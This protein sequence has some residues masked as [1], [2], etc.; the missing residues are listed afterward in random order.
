LEVNLRKGGTTH[1]YTVLRNLVPGRYDSEHGRWLAID[2]RFGLTAIGRS[3]EQ[4]AELYQATKSAV[5]GH[6]NP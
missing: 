3:Q 4:A 5:D 2:G 6:T 1:P